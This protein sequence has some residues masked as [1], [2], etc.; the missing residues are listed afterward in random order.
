[1]TTPSRGS[2]PC[3]WRPQRPAPC[4]TRSTPH[5]DGLLPNAY[6]L[7]ELSG[8]YIVIAHL[9]DGVYGKVS[10]AAVVSRMRSTF[11]QLKFGVMVGIGGGVPGGKNDIR[12]GDVVVSKS[13]PN[14]N[15][16]IQYDYGKAVQGGNLSKRAS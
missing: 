6:E 2:V 16:V 10:A 13:G 12:L 4:S 15:G 7:G 8:H 9:P 3:L 14:H 1:M 5:L 11:R